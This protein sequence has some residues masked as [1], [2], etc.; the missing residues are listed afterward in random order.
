MYI[1]KRPT[2]SKD[3]LLKRPPLSKGILRRRAKEVSQALEEAWTR[4]HNF[5][6]DEL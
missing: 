5:Q 6:Y 3:A 1:N 2:S 4:Q